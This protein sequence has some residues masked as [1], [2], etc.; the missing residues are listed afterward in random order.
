MNLR[1]YVLFYEPR[2]LSRCSK[3]TLN[4]KLSELGGSEE[5]AVAQSGGSMGRPCRS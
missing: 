3:E 4:P 5:G 2:F 1:P